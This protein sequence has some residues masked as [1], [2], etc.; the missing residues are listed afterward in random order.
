V[1]YTSFALRQFLDFWYLIGG[2]SA[3]AIADD[4]ISI[5]IAPF[6]SA[7]HMLLSNFVNMIP[8]YLERCPIR[9]RMISCA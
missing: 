9:E 1:Q 3:N 5:S 6:R 2:F 4:P 8:N 7:I